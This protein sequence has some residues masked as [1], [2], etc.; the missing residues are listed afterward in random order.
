[1]MTSLAQCGST[2]RETARGMKIRLME[3]LK[4]THSDLL[5]Y[6]KSPV[7]KIEGLRGGE[8]IRMYISGRTV[9]RC[10]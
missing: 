1:M 5:S 4:L 9:G 3:V 10:S 2:E 6:P 7:G 8:Y